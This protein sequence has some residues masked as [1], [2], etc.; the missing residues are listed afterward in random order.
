MGSY[1]YQLQAPLAGRR[2]RSAVALLV[3]VLLLCTGA[4]LRAR[5]ATGPSVSVIVQKVSELDQLP[6]RAVKALGGTVTRELWIVNGFSAKV[7]QSQLSR[8]Q[9][10]PGVVAV[11]A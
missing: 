5:A 7:P 10:T 11:R 1:A 8:L 3:G 9:A 6:E 4:Q 2:L